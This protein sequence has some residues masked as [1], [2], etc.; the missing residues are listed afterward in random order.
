MPFLSARP[1]IEEEAG[2]QFEPL[3]AGHYR[4]PAW[5]RYSNTLR[6]RER[7][8]NV[9]ARKGHLTTIKWRY[10]CSGCTAIRVSFVVSGPFAFR[11]K[12]ASNTILVAMEASTEFGPSELSLD[13]CIIPRERLENTPSFKDGVS[14]EL[15]ANLRVVGCEYIQSAGLLLK[16]PQV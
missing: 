14:H 6:M 15:E 12:D 5:L 16:L 3:P 9:I 4:I 10:V 11:L 8:H 2:L 1:S 13:N 7:K